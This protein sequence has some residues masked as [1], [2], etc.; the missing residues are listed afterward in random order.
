M[1]IDFSL[2]DEQKM[3]LDTVR[4]FKEKECP[5]EKVAEWDNAGVDFPS[6]LWKKLG[7]IGVLGLGFPEKYGGIPGGM[8]DE[9]LIAE[10][11]SYGFNDLA[12]GYLLGVS[13]G[14]YSILHQG[15]DEQKEKYLPP[16]IR[17]ET[18]FALGLT[19]PGG[20]L[21]ILN[22]L[23]TKVFTTGMHVADTIVLVVRTDDVPGRPTRGLTIFL[24][25][26]KTPGIT[27]NK[28]EKLGSHTMATYEVSYEDVKVHKSQIL[29][30][31]G[32][33]WYQIL[34]TLNNERIIVA[35]ECC[36]IAR[37]AFDEALQYA[38]ER[39][40]FGK[41]IGQHMAI[42]H[43]LA[44]MATEIE[45]A[46][47]L[48]Y[49]AA[50]LVDTAKTNE[51]LMAAGG[52]ATMCKYWA[53]DVGQRVTDK[54]MRILAGYGFMMEYHMQR[55]FRNIRQLIFAPITNEMAKNIIGQMML[56]LGKSY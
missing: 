23:K 34:G 42:Q 14:G 2:T 47:L 1:P 19:E 51:E 20:G 31:R 11:L 40:A 16:L 15:N 48:T 36:G 32:K 10:E 5:K 9:A 26:K 18:N 30:E 44:E 12:L 13:F 28:L 22:A 33:G 52:T 29:G 21:D 56:G 46:R 4:K 53:S 39:E 24:V 37:C 35:A 49:K 7:D 25:D 8:L 43:Y 41:P 54:G 45:T 55:Y 27:Y 6:E 38:K 17:G 50:W 3:I